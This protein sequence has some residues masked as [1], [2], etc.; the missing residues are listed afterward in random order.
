MT[1]DELAFLPERV[2]K[3]VGQGWRLIPQSMDKSTPVK[4]RQFQDASPS[5]SDLKRWV[6]DFPNCMW[7]V[8]TGQASGVIVLD[9]GVKDG[10]METLRG[11]DL[12]PSIL[13]PSGGAH[14][15][16]WAPDFKVSGGARLD[17]EQFPGMDVPADGEL[18]TVVGKNHLSGGEYRKA[19]KAKVYRLDDLPTDLRRFVTDRRKA[20]QKKLHDEAKEWRHKY[21]RLEAELAERGEPA[22]VDALRIQAEFFKHAARDVVDLDAAMK[23]ADLSAVTISEDGTV[24][25]MADAVAEVCRQYPFLAD[26]PDAWDDDPRTRTTDV[27]AESGS[28]GS[29][30]NR[31][32]PAGGRSNTPKALM[33]K[34]PALYDRRR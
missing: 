20:G 33:E 32:R 17:P 10:G 24:T 15:Y 3:L 27:P 28:G 8:V 6:H 29:P 30:S 16:V 7:A 4:W 13:T 9:F 1:G 14:V 26:D 12:R 18:A 22:D 2:A 19:K 23:L 34:F 11:L 21:R 25:G 5:T 31:R